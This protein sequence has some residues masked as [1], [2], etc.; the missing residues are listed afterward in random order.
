MQH[1]HKALTQMNLQ[2]HHV[3]SDI[4]GISGM[5]IVEAI[6]DG[7]RDAGKLAALCHGSV[8]SDRQTIVKS[9]VG[10][11][12]AEHLFTLRQS[13]AAYRNYQQ[14][15]AECDRQIE[16]LTQ[17]LNGKNV[18][19]PKPSA[20]SQSTHKHRKNQ[21]YCDMGSELKRVLGVDLERFPNSRGLFDAAEGGIFFHPSDEDLSPGTP[22]GK[23]HS[24]GTV[25]VYTNSGTAVTSIPGISA[26]T[27]H[28]LLAE[29]GPTSAASPTLQ[30]SPVG[31]LCARPTRRAEERCY[32]RKRARVIAVPVEHY[33]SPPKRWPAAAPT[34][35][36]ST[37]ACV[38]A[39]DHP[40]PSPPP[41]TN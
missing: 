35:A 1:V 5:A 17:Q 8:R 18:S 22:A 15:M 16:Q 13:L 2:I 6:V 11:Y 24:T 33:A 4:T 12:R 31:L 10:N 40:R 20:S 27:A 38:P 25:S 9:L 34:W 30:P 36:I 23:C 32:R 3:L 41:P 19:G 37:A 21:F 14:M 28:T 26:L 7:E 39:S 29:I